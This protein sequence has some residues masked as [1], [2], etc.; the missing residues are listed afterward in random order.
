MTTILGG[1]V[2][3]RALIKDFV[4]AG[5]CVARNEPAWIP[6]LEFEMRNHLSQK[7][8][9]FR[10]NDVRF[11]VAYLHGKPVGRLSLQIPAA[12][13]ARTSQMDKNDE[14]DCHHRNVTHN[15]ST[16]HFGFCAAASPDIFQ[17]LLA[18]GEDWLLDK[19]CTMVRGPFSLSINDEVG[20]LV[21]GTDKKP[22][23]L[24]NY[25]PAWMRQTLENESYK[26]ARD[27]FAYDLET[28]RDLPE[29]AQKMAGMAVGSDRIESRTIKSRDLLGDLEI[30]RDIFN[31]GWAGNWGFVPMT[32]Q[33]IRYMAHSMSPILDTDLAR[34]GYIDGQPS[35]MIVALP[36]L[37][38]A[39]DDFQGRLFPL[40]WGRLIWHLKVRGVKSARVLLMG[41]V[42][43]HHSGILGSA[44]SILLIS[45]IHASLREKGY[46]E[47][48]LSWILEDNTPIRKMIESLGGSV[49]RT[50]RVFE[51]P[52]TDKDK[53]ADLLKG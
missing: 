9:F 30:I 16:G 8:P 53:K 15:N 18:T 6:R 19:G 4:Q 29:R 51:K 10:D 20:L 17:S 5:T 47:V 12:R 35:A 48:E 37:N 45:Q 32:S 36:N 52:L 21:K 46:R 7:N 50:Y 11:L 26:K 31:R 24:M 42:P 25:A 44:L 13:P 38:E 41:V 14:N 33:D 27:L 40:N 28:T 43:E 49:T 1:P 2:T 39:I 3:D 34:I 23:L 22:R